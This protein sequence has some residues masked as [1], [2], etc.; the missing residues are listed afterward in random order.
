MSR[1]DVMCIKGFTIKMTAPHLDEWALH[2]LES[3]GYYEI[4]MMHLALV[5]L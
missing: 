2:V 4:E 3:V 5:F 1:K